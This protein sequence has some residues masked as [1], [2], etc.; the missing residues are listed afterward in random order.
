MEMKKIVLFGAGGFAK[1]VANMINN[2]N[3]I[4]V[5]YELL[6]F[7]VER[8]YFKQGEIINGL[9]V[10]GDENW[11]LDHKDV[12]CT[13][14]I[15]DVYAKKRIHEFLKKNSIKLETII[16]I[17]GYVSPHSV[18]GEGCVIYPYVLVSENVEIGEGVLLNSYVSVGHDVKIGSFTNVM[19]GTGISGN[20][21]IGEQVNIGGHAF[22]VPHK[23]IGDKAVVAAGS[24]VFSNV[25]A[26]TT[27][28]GNPAMR[29]RAIE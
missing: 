11:I 13:C 6:G 22:I 3:H 28:L 5:T 26:G 20:V 24:I 8:K 2:I 4:K 7:I 1:E 12:Y 21:Q 9:S 15:S 10:L 29:I 25:K 18:V 14:V 23:K 27:V 17:S 19:P 16:D